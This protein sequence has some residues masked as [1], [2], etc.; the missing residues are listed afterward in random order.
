LQH[1][2]QS[3]GAAV[4][5]ANHSQATVTRFVVLNTQIGFQAA[6]NTTLRLGQSAFTRVIDS[7]GNANFVGISINRGSY[8]R[9]D[10]NAIISISNVGTG[11]SVIRSGTFTVDAATSIFNFNNV[12]VANIHTENLSVWNGMQQTSTPG[13][14]F[15]Y[16]AAPGIQEMENAYQNQVIN[17]AVPINIPLN[18]SAN[19]SGTLRKYL[20]KTFTV[21]LINAGGVNSTIT[22]TGASFVG[23]G[24]SG[25]VATFSSNNSCVT[26]LVESTTSVRVLSSFGMT[27]P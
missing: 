21:S 12:T 11:V 19:A 5:A 7:T 6:G 26:L 25:N 27:Y 1:A 23:F 17:T 20:G 15:Y 4:N 10:S 24:A 22:L 18:P 2:S 13:N 3:G 16:T 8:G 9:I 14:V